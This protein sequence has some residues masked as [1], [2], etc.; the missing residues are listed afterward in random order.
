MTIERTLRGIAGIFILVSVALG[1]FHSPLWFLLTLFVGINLFQSAFSNWCPMKSI[2]E[3]S[4]MKPCGQQNR[5]SHR[6]M[7]FVLILSIAASTHSYVATQELSGK[8]IV[9][10]YYDAFYSQGNDMWAKVNMDLIGKDGQKRNRQMVMLRKDVEGAGN[11]KYFIYFFEPGDVRRTSFL[12]YKYPGKD[13]E[14]WIFIPAVDLVKRV[15]AQDKRS[16]FI[17]SDFTYE[18]ISGRDVDSDDHKL[19]RTEKM[20]GRDSYVVES[21]PREKVEYTKRISWIDKQNFL[22]LKE[23]YYDQQNQLY[24]VFTG[25]E[26]KEIQ[27]E[28][29]GSKTFA[30]IMKRTMENVKTSHKTEVVFTSIKYDTG[31]EENAFTE[32][33][34]RNPPPQWIK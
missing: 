4:G 25:S 33:S 29:A 11:Q 9:G 10:K 18:D 7:L 8:D 15:A 20:N 21:I 13:D 27:T 24:K 26:A 1:Y 22:P 31:I 5:P 12:V 14:R 30:T 34:L 3:W 17:G 6:M 16:S 2:L 32:R 23:E 28:S 19:V